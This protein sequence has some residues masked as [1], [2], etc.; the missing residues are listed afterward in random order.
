M[1]LGFGFYEIG[2][3]LVLNFKLPEKVGGLGDMLHL[4]SPIRLQRPQQP[5]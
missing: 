2:D 3:W 5:R 4:L 1:P